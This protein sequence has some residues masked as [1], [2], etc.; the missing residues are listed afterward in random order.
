VTRLDGIP[1]SVPA[2]HALILGSGLL[3]VRLA[4]HIADRN[5]KLANQPRNGPVEHI[6]LIGLSDLSVLFMKFL[7]TG[8]PGRQRV[9][10]VLEAEPRWIGRSVDGI[11]VFGPPGHLETLIDEFAVHGVTTNRVVVGSEPGRLPPETLTTI[12]QLCATR[13]LDLLFVADLF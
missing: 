11:P 12:R 3:L 9:I 10:G 5:R 4:A 7:E 13:G 2:I 1:R 8:A 6:I